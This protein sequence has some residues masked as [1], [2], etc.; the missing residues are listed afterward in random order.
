MSPLSGTLIA[1]EIALCLNLWKID[2]KIFSITSDNA[3]YDDSMAISLKGSLFSKKYLFIGGA[4]SQIRCCCQLLNVIVESSLN[5][6]DDIV[7]KIRSG[8]EH[9]RKFTSRKKK[10]YL[11]ASKDFLLDTKK[12]LRPDV[13]SRWNTTYLMLERFL[14]Y[15]SMLQS[16]GEQD[17]SFMYYNLSDEEWDKVAMIQKFLAVFYD[18]EYTFSL[19][20]EP[21]SNLYFRALWKVHMHLLKAVR[22]HCNFMSSMVSNM[23]G[24]FEKYWIKH[25]LILSCAAVLD[26]RFKVK[27][28]EFCYTKIYGDKAEEFV[29]NT[30]R[31][32]YSLFD[33]YKPNSMMSSSCTLTSSG[34]NIDEHRHADGDEFDDYEQFLSS[35]SRPQDEKSQ[36]DLYLEEP[37]HDLNSDINVLEYW[38]NS[39]MRYPDL[40]MMARDILTM[41]ISSIAPESSF[42][43]GKKELN[44]GQFSLNPKMIQALVCLSDWTS[45]LDKSFGAIFPILHEYGDPSASDDEIDYDDWDI[46]AGI[47]S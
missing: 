27:L 15:K 2:T 8:I 45:S 1:E 13:C 34:P 26:P 10:F 17:M 28:V 30:V 11:I 24:K 18:V 29:N 14:Y 47:F 38:N 43:I 21:T 42:S 20:K 35:K 16:W 6:V 12:R 25:N 9:I 41:P 46:E 7:D 19:T 37:G 3:L 4:F 5:L 39:S 36:L 32:L 40:A 31:T 23:Q 33:E 44:P 22:G